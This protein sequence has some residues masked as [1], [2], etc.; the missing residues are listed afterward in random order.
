M[1]N[2]TLP[3]LKANAADHVAA[4]LKGLAGVAPV[5][6]GAIAELVSAIIPNQRID[7]VTRFATALDERLCA[8]EARPIRDEISDGHFSDLLEDALQ[9][10]ARATSTERIE[11]LAEIVSKSL[12]ADD[13]SHGER[14]HLMR[15]L[16]ELTDVEVIWLGS[17]L[18]SYIGE[19]SAFQKRHKNVLEP[20]RAFLGSPQP[21]LD[22]STLQDS[23]KAHLA[24]LGLLDR[25]IQ[26]D[27]N[28]Q[29]EIDGSTGD[30][31]V[32]SYRITR[33]GKLLLREIGLT[34]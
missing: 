14:K 26:L 2:A 6:G 16:S 3:S 18:N 27:R 9:Q 21:E 24:Q 13:I 7:R 32:R 20:R 33:L 29:P 31:K 34:D 12:T 30:F 25:S 17:F 19:P 4:A 10:A 1:T 8:L 28:K 23:Y 22:K 15:I 11:Q 5:V